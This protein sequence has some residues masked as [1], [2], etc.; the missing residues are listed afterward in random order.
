MVGL[1]PPGNV[2]R[3]IALF[4]R[5]VFR[6]TGDTSALAFPEVVPLAFSAFSKS[7]PESPRPR[8]EPRPLDYARILTT[9]S[10]MWD[11][12]AGSF[13]TGEIIE[14]GSGLYLLVDGP[15]E[16]LASQAALRLAG[17]GAA[18]F[19][20]PPLA[21]GLGFFICLP[22]AAGAG[23]DPLAA[24]ISGL[25]PPR[26]AFRDSSLLLAR[27]TLGPD[28][29]AAGR[30]RPLACSLRRGPQ[31]RPAAGDRPSTGAR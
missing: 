11:G 13:N 25:G 7:A 29:F 20:E 17:F 21:C 15:L 18:P 12:V 27:L 2:A 8:R 30:W 28:P 31:D 22:P 23:A 1:E 19:V 6:G 16:A 14:R 9:P 4:R 10:P 24:L 26:L 5:R 3:E